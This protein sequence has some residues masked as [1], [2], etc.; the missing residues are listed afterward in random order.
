MDNGLEWNKQGFD[1]KVGNIAILKFEYS[2]TDYICDNN[3]QIII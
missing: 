2:P 1:K 3:G